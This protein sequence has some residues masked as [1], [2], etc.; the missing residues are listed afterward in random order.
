LGRESYR[1]I[2]NPATRDAGKCEI[3]P[4]GHMLYVDA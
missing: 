4:R 3:N 1:L 2:H